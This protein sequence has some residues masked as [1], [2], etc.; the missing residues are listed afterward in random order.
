MMET[1]VRWTLFQY[2]KGDRSLFYKGTT[3]VLEIQD[4]IKHYLVFP[5]TM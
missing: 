2:F 4:I 3:H 1:L 5:N